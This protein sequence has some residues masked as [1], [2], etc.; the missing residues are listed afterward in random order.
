MQ[1]VALIKQ[2]NEQKQCCTAK[3]NQVIQALHLDDDDP[4]GDARNL[5]KELRK[6]LAKL[7]Q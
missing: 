7:Q 2:L 4:V 6:A 3:L 1:V 5:A